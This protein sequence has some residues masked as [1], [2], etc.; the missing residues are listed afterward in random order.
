MPNGSRSAGLHLIAFFLLATAA[1][2]PVGAQWIT[3]PTPGIPH[4]KD[5]KPDLSAPAP[6]T[7]DGKPDLSGMWYPIKTAEDAFPEFRGAFFDP[8]TSINGLPY[9]PWAA[10]LVRARKANNSKDHPNAKCL[11]LAPPQLH[12]HP[13]NRRIIQLPGSLVTLFERDTNF[14]VIYT[15]GR[16]LPADPQPSWFGYSTGKWEGDVFVAETNGF[17]DDTWVDQIGSPMTSS[18]RLTERFRRV[19]FGILEIEM[20]INDPKAYTRP[21]TVK[22]QQG[23]VADGQLI[24]WFCDDEKDQTHLVGK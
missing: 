8:G 11:P 6:K 5:G 16:P 9:Q 19:N 10:E 21:W 4:T 17:K 3:Y 7:T 2:L 23:L 24:E 12:T 20:T 13:S 14:R 1:S 18:G 22:I 15:D